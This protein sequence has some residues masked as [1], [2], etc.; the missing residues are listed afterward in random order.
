MDDLAA[1]T[2]PGVAAETASGADSGLGSGVIAVRYFAAARAAA[3]VESE[4]LPIAAQ[5]TL[6]GLEGQLA[7]LH[8]ERLAD[9]LRRCSYL[10]DGLAVTDRTTALAGRRTVDVLPPFAGG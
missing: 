5:A 1:D 2:S 4:Q 6:G 9:V 7:R 10:V 3:G 8:G